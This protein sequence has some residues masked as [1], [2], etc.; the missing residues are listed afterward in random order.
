M[1]L[2]LSRD[3]LP[4]RTKCEFVQLRAIHPDD[5]S[6]GTIAGQE[7]SVPGLVDSED[8]PERG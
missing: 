2:Q 1:N 7:G 4:R 8:V 5:C 6:A 3:S